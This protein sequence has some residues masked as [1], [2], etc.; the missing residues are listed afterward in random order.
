MSS[1]Q[2]KL[3]SKTRTTVIIVVLLIIFIVVVL[4]LAKKAGREDEKL[5][6]EHSHSRAKEL[7]K[8]LK[9]SVSP[10]AN[11]LINPRREIKAANPVEVKPAGN[12]IAT[13][14]MPQVVTTP[15]ATSPTSIP[16]VATITTPS[17]TIPSVAATP[18]VNTTPAV[19]CSSYNDRLPETPVLRCYDYFEF[20]GQ[21]T[22][23]IKTCGAPP[24][25][26]T[27]QIFI[28]WFPVEN[29]KNYNIYCNQ[30]EEV[31]KTNYSAKWA[32]PGSSYYFESEKL[33]ASKCWSLTVTSQNDNGESG[34]S[35]IYTT[36]TK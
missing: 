24:D 23:H 1:I 27:K 22:F 21:G 28:Q 20:P 26:S 14:T 16:S 10:T 35:Q 7:T 9:D 19:V 15:S 13:P 5:K 17:I 6:L 18:V 8:E 25:Q 12:Q 31:S 32:I 4:M 33:D 11:E 34:E 3:D 30:G 2:I 29:V 36:C